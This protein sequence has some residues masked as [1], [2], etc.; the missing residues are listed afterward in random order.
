M[1]T[2]HSPVVSH[3][4]RARRNA[5]SIVCVFLQAGIID[6]KPHDRLPALY[7]VDERTEVRN[8]SILEAESVPM[9][10]LKSCTRTLCPG[11]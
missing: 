1:I 2:V 3:N 11:R 8:S 9:T 6:A 4:D 10:Q 7:S 5:V